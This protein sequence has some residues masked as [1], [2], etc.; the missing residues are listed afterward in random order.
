VTEAPRLPSPDEQPRVSRFTH[1]LAWVLWFG[2][3]CVL[4]AVGLVLVST[5]F[6]PSVLLILAP[7][8]TGLPMLAFLARRYGANLVNW[9]DDCMVLRSCGREA[10][11][12]WTDIASFH[13][14][15]ATHKIGGGGQA[16]IATLV[17]YRT[18]T[19][20]YRT[21]LLTVSGSA[22][23]EACPQPLAAARYQTVFDIRTSA[24][25]RSLVSRR[26]E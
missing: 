19:G 6:P 10:H 11:I 24:T 15:W 22:D 25:S 4:A 9:N 1:L 18:E 16:W 26:K 23:A 20:R 21:V 12:A 7:F 8:V 14:L 5:G 3:P 13:K 17:K 2:L